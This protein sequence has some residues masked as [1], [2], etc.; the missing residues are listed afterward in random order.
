MPNPD[1]DKSLLMIVQVNNRFVLAVLVRVHARQAER[2]HEVEG[3]IPVSPFLM[4]PIPKEPCLRFPS[5]APH[6]MYSRYSFSTDSCSLSTE[7][8]S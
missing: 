7:W 5:T 4:S 1:I 2:N 3:Q 8:R 6:R